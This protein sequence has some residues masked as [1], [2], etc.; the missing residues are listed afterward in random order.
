MSRYTD[1]YEIS[2]T[3]TIGVAVVTFFG[4]VFNVG[5]IDGDAAGLLLRSVI[6]VFVAL[7]L[8]QVLIGEDLRDGCG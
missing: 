4:R 2:M 3:G 1:L 5:D 8:G 6:N 7:V